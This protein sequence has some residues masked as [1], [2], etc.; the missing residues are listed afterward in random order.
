MTMGRNLAEESTTL[1]A[2][3]KRPTAMVLHKLWIS[4]EAMCFPLQKASSWKLKARM[5]MSKVPP[6]L[7]GH[8]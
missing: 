2:S 4:A 1:Q 8:S 7:G 3:R 6:G 5:L